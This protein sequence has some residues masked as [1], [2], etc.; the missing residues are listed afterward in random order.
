MAI[1]TGSLLLLEVLFDIL[2]EYLPNTALSWINIALFAISFVCLTIFLKKLSSELS[3]Y[4]NTL[5]NSKKLSYGASG[6]LG[7]MIFKT[8]SVLIVPYVPRVLLLLFFLLFGPP[9]I[10]AVAFSRT[11][12]SLKEFE[13][14][15][16]TAFSVYAWT[17][18]TALVLAFFMFIGEAESAGDVILTIGFWADIVLL[19]IIAIVIILQADKFSIIGKIAVTLP[20]KQVP[21]MHPT[22]QPHYPPTQPQALQVP[23]QAIPQTEEPI[24]KASDRFCT[25]CGAK[26]QPNSKFC[27]ICGAELED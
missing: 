20:P 5:D 1:I 9:F 27:E 25:N 8:I 11:Y 18:V 14:K 7:Y 2:R 4:Q 13:Y 21:G 24:A 17:E 12:K 3:L 16:L 22:V 26:A 23:I 15:G 19:T 10:K 6:V